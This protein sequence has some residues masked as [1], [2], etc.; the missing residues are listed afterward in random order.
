MVPTLSLVAPD[1]PDGVRIW[2]DERLRRESGVVIGFS[3]RGGGVSAPPFDTLNLASHV[4]DDPSSV[5]EN[6]RRLLRAAGI[7][8][9]RHR[10]T[11]A[12]QVHGTSIA[13]VD[14]ANAGSGAC[15]AGGPPPIAGTDALLTMVPETPLALC[16][17]DC[18]PV[19]LVAPGPAVCVLH[20]GWR[21]ALESL[22]GT[23]V[24]ELARVAG[25]ESEQVVAYIGP[26][27]GACH[28]EVAP[29]LLSQFVNTFGTLA[30]AASGGL[31][32]DAAVTVSLDRA[33]VTPCNIARLG[34]CTAET[35]DRFFSY[36]AEGGR[37]GRHSGI[38]CIVARS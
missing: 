12:E 25:C 6:R 3:E 37:T 20:A 4:G 21:G 10:L 14:A 16:F 36:R 23:G 24:T 31:D 15:A 7:E 27:I 28:Y 34:S 13:I 30:R 35:T 33:G 26:H 5:D 19:V 38:A 8:G 22:P 1:G 32:L 11:M 2:T 9:V 17:A 18:V 29:D